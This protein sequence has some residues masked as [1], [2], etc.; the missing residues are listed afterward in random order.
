MSEIDICVKTNYKGVW[1]SKRI[2]A[3]LAEPSE[4]M[5]QAM[6][7]VKA[8]F[9][10]FVKT[11]DKQVAKKEKQANGRADSAALITEILDASSFECHHYNSNTAWTRR[12]GSLVVRFDPACNKFSIDLGSRLSPDNTIRRLTYYD[13]IRK[14]IKTGSISAKAR[15]YASSFMEKRK[16]K[17]A[18]FD[19][20]Y[21]LLESLEPLRPKDK[22]RKTVRGAMAEGR[23]L[24]QIEH[25][26]FTDGCEWN[27]WS[28]RAHALSNTF[29]TPGGVVIV[30]NKLTLQL[31]LGPDL[32][33][34]KVCQPKDLIFE[35]SK[36]PFILRFISNPEYNPNPE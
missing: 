11:R 7:R 14:T 8:E 26:Y 22:E 31:T 30:I 34:Q 36:I 10:R 32:W 28:N 19:Q 16:K 33:A 5:A 4:S 24:D 21:K 17:E 25:Y 9:A 1:F 6:D 35:L 13:T 2:S 3:D 27:S 23:A 20:V 29:P 12:R 15:K 18:K